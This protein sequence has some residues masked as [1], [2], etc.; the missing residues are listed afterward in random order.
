MVQGGVMVT[1]DHQYLHTHRP[2]IGSDMWLV[3]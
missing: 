3:A 1:T 2:L